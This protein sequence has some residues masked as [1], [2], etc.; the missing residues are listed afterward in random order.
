LIDGIP[1]FG[2]AQGTTGVGL[3]LTMTGSVPFTPGGGVEAYEV[4]AVQ[5]VITDDLPDAVPCAAE[6]GPGYINLAIRPMSQ[7]ETCAVIQD[8]LGT[9]I[10]CYDVTDLGRLQPSCARLSLVA[11]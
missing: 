1:P 5:V 10:S 11:G 3:S 4:S 9:M 7:A 2:G 8:A 6:F